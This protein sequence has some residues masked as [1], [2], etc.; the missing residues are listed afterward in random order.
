MSAEKVQS[1]KIRPEKITDNFY[2]LGTPFF[3]VYLS[4]GDDAMLIEGGTGGIY[5]LILDQ[6]D[7][8]GVRPEKIKY[9][10]LTHSHADHVGLI[11]HLTDKWE[12]VKFLATEKASELLQNENVIKQFID[13]D[14]FIAERLKSIGETTE[15]APEIEEYKFNIDT[16]IDE[17]DKIELGGDVTWTVSMLGGHSPCQIALHEKN[18]GIIVVGDAAGLYFPKIDQFWPEY[19]V[20]LEQYCDSIRK[21]AAFPANYVALSHFG[22]V[23]SDS[24]DFL[25]KSLK[26]TEAYHNEMIERMNNGEELN[27][28][29][30]EKANWVLTNHNYMTFEIT[31]QMC[32]L[33]IKRS[34]KAADKSDL[35]TDF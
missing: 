28:I 33:L 24:R 32:R 25:R 34:L 23:N 3:P 17:G 9:I 10:A 11:P 35:F 5:S 16:I 29:A 4:I 20:S 7:E 19:F 21:L 31:E 13:M 22:I 1:E 18:H 27:D 15:L 2:K 30:L 8:L 14:S 6:L 12:H 26:A